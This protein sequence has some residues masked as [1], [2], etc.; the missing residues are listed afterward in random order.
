MNKQELIDKAVEQFSGVW[1]G[2]DNGV[3]YFNP[4]AKSPCHPFW[5]AYDKWDVYGQYVCTAGEFT[6]RARELGWINGYKYGVVYQANDKKPDLPEGALLEVTYVCGTK[7]KEKLN[8]TTFDFRPMYDPRPVSFRIV[9]ERYKPVEVE[10]AASVKGETPKKDLSDFSIQLS[11]IAHEL[12]DV[13]EVDY[14]KRLTELSKEIANK[15]RQKLADEEKK[16]FVDAACA[17][18][19]EN[20]T[21]MPNELLGM[22]YDA[23]CRFTENKAAS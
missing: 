10:Q 8:K 21:A 19:D 1:K 7:T 14:A 3:L 11:S 4:S 16:K 2:A 9:D 12:I 5:L 13:G 22:L 15:Q 6:Q 17:I 18:L 23:G 20:P